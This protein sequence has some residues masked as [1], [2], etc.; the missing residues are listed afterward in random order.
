MPPT[1]KILPA[2]KMRKVLRCFFKASS[3]IILGILLPVSTARIPC[4]RIQP[5]LSIKAMAVFFAVACTAAANTAIEPV[6]RSKATWH[7]RHQALVKEANTAKIDVLFL[8]DSITDFWRDP[9]R[10]KPVWDKYFQPLH[11]A[12]FGISGDRTQNVLW[13]LRNG[14]AEGY[15]PKV[16]VLL[17]GTNN[18]GFEK[19]KK[20][21][22]NSP[23]EVVEGITAVVQEVRS[24]FPSAKI[25]LL[26]IFPREDRDASLQG[27]IQQINREISK[28]NDDRNI[29]YLDIGQKFLD[30]KGS[31]LKDAMPDLLHPSRKGYE[32]WAEAM[33]QTLDRLLSATN[34]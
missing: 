27:Q 4:L 8:G 16:V 13:R 23:A 33:K 30:A 10:G 18:T 31:V 20:T 24:K 9:D 34:S 15:M 29:F 11:A 12:N 3:S 22:R 26:A 21:P 32:I 7:K 2:K 14:E 19:D 5:P 28:L 17:V 1:P 6:P 25:L